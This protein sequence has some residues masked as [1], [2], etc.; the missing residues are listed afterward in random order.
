MISKSDKKILQELAK[1]VAE[2]A[3]LPIMEK[4]RKLW[5]KLNKLERTRPLILVFPENSW[6]ELLPESALKCS[7]QKAR[8]YEWELRSRIYEHENFYHDKPVEKNWI[9]HK[10]ITTTGW[11]LEA[12]YHKSSSKNGAR[13]YNPVIKEAADLEKL[14][15][16]EVKYDKEQTEKELNL[17]KE[18]FA[19]ILNVKLKGV[20]RIDFHLMQLYSDLR[21]L[22]QVML[23]MYDNPGMLHQ[24]MSIFTAGYKHVLQ[25]YQEMNL[26]DLN[27]DETYNNSGGVGYTDQ[28]PQSDFNKNDKVRLSDMWGCAESQELAQVSPAM[29]NEFAL[30]YEKELLAPFGLTGYGCCEP[31]TDKLEDVFEIPNIRR[32]S[33]SP[34]ADVEIC[35]E[36]MK[37][38]YIFSWKPNP[39]HI[40]GNFDHKQ[41]K[42]IY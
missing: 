16:P 19:D 28:L 42:K 12:K 20:D 27:N 7:G 35:A 14:R 2:F 41:I 33:I 5:I 17:T 13:T 31:L 37:D 9:V 3:N 24:A 38:N 4:R 25:Q 36:K 21:G 8:K 18:L 29:H 39:A 34:W 32:I 15:Y 22:N 26:L 6:G 23:D 10:V 40:V 11:G 30:K 1:R